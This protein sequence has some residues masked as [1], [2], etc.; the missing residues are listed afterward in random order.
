MKVS[1][2]QEAKILALAGLAPDAPPDRVAPD[3]IAP[4]VEVRA[5]GCVLELPYP[6]TVNTYWRRVGG[7]TILSARARAYRRAVLAATTGVR[8]EPMAGDVEAV[9]TFHPPDRRKR[10][11]D[12]LPKGLLDALKCAGVYA[13]DSQVRRIDMRFG[14]V[15]SGGLAV[16]RV[17]SLQDTDMVRRRCG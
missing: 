12:N 9:I 2:E 13:D 17:R 15:R 14:E 7:K 6:P 5:D 1:R 16:V 4:H 11:L 3:L 10:D 8:L